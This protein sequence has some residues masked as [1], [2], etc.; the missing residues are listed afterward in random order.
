MVTGDLLTGGILGAFFGGLAVA[1]A[2]Y[3]YISK[4]ITP[5]EA[6][7]IYDKAQAA[8][9]EYNRAR[10]DGTITTEEKLKIAEKA[11]STLETVIKSMES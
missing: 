7:E 8:I 5:S 1:G 9:D 10:E 6:K 2:A 3:R 4:S 11:L